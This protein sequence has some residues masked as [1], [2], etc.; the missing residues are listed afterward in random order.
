M[1]PFNVFLFFYKQVTS[2]EFLKKSLLLFWLFF[3]LIMIS[4]I[5]YNDLCQSVISYNDN[6]I[7]V[8]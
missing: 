1:A 3:Q 7:G 4:E 2:T 8:A 6:S 5:A